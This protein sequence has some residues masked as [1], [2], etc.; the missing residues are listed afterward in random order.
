MIKFEGALPP[1]QVFFFC[2]M[3]PSAVRRLLPL[4]L[5]TLQTLQSLCLRGSELN[6]N[7][8]SLGANAGGGRLSISWWIEGGESQVDSNCIFFI[9]STTC[10]ALSLCGGEQIGAPAMS[11]MEE[12]RDKHGK[13]IP[14]M[15]IHIRRGREVKV[16]NANYKRLLNNKDKV[17]RN[18][19]L[20]FS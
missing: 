5:G 11:Q 9:G 12:V 18:S 2:C 14:R 3:S 20:V 13:V 1:P 10:A 17:K 19:E 6:S 16:V 8:C 7:S 4:F 15:C